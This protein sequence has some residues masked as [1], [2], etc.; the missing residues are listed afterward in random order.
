LDLLLKVPE[1]T[2]QEKWV[3]VAL[4][5]LG[6]VRGPSI[7][8]RIAVAQDVLVN[9]FGLW[10]V[11][12]HEAK[13][14]MQRGRAVRTHLID[15]TDCRPIQMEDLALY[16]EEAML[17]WAA[18]H[19]ISLSDALTAREAFAKTVLQHAERNDP[20]AQFLASALYGQGYGLPL[21]SSLALE[22]L[23]KAAH[24]GSCI[25]QCTLGYIYALG[26]GRDKD[27]SQAE[28]W[29]EASCAKGFP[30]ASRAISLLDL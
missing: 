14:S 18:S 26:I 13:E 29:L 21:N 5:P 22:W 23:M 10:K 28:K 7:R 17:T 12:A 4:L 30:P 16:Q 9:L 27:L 6:K 2:F 3:S 1:E 8:D 19:A 24:G 25:A 15:K 11:A 20:E